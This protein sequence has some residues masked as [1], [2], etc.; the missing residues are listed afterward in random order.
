MT[1]LPESRER[2]GVSPFRVGLGYD[3]HRTVKGR[4]LVLGGVEIPSPFGLEGH[5]DADCLCHAIADALLGS[6][7]LPD[8]GHFFPNTDPTLKGISSLILLEKVAGE[9][10]DRGWEIGNVDAMLIAEAPPVSPYR[11]TMRQKVAGALGCDPGQ[12]GIKATTNEGQDATG[13]SEAIAAHAV[14]LVWHRK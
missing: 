2:A 11:E 14:A 12:V 3:I 6:V 13:R 5:S 1:D 4:P 8:I 9:L 7:G 10:R